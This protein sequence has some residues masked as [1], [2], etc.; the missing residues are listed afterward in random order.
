MCSFNASAGSGIEYIDG[1][2]TNKASSFI[3]SFTGLS[4][5]VE[6]K[7]SLL[8]VDN[9]VNMFY[10]CVELKRIDKLDISQISTTTSMFSNLPKL[11]EIVF[12]NGI[13]VS[14][15]LSS[16]PNLT[17]NT[18]IHIFNSLSNRNGMSS[19]TLKIGSTNI[20]KLTP[21]Q[22]AIATSKNWIIA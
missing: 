17:V 6:V 15:D 1:L 11:E 12:V 10:N 19:F 8:K 4:K 3:N 18:L 13:N 22:L 21:E 2:I 5:L 20:A 9:G 7:N 16:S 14:I